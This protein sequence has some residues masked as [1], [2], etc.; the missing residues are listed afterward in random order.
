MTRLMHYEELERRLEAGEDNLDLSIEKW[1][2]AIVVWKEDPSEVWIEALRS[3]SCGLCS[4]HLEP[5]VLCWPAC[6]TCPY[7]LTYGKTCDAGNMH[8]QEMRQAMSVY[9]YDWAAAPEDREKQG[10]VVLE[11]FVRMLDALLY[12]REERE[13]EESNGGGGTVVAPEGDDG[14]STSED[15]ALGERVPGQPPVQTVSP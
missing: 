6:T 3:N 1:E 14:E 8:W 2:R 9:D 12:I 11:T 5:P 4:N 7:V 15:L 10:A 13:L